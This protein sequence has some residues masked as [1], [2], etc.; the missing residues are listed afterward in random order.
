MKGLLLVTNYNKYAFSLL[1]TI[2]LFITTNPITVLANTLDLENPSDYSSWDN[3]M[4]VI[5]IIFY[6]LIIIGL[7]IM[8]IK[9]LAHKNRNLMSNKSI[10]S[11]T[12]VQLGQNKSLQVVEIG[13]SIYVIGVGDNVQLIEKISAEDEINDIKDSLYSSNSFTGREKFASITDWFVNL[14]KNRI[15]KND[16]EDSAISFQEV[17]KKK[18]NQVSGRKKRLEELLS[19]EDKK[20]RSSER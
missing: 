15:L 14:K 3:F 4:T 19:N 12:G 5:K 16:N 18:M 10:K 20:D 17:F 8:S 7:I 11:L 13:R 9:F 2:L 1:S 6:L